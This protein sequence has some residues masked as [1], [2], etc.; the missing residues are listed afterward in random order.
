MKL[1]LIS[2]FALAIAVAAGTLVSEDPGFIVI[3]YGG[4]VVRTT[5]AFFLL[6]ALIVAIA[7][8]ATIRVFAN[9]IELRRRWQRW[10]EEQ[11][12]RRAHRS[13]ANGLLAFASGDFERAER[14]FSRGVDED[15]QPE[16]HYLAAAE[17][18]QA[19]HAPAR[20][21]N[22]LRLAHDLQPEASDAI[23]IKRAEW[24]IENSQLEEARE[25]LDG[26][27]TRQRGNA[28]LL[29]LRLDLIE[30]LGDPDALIALVP[31]L[32][33]A[34]VVSFDAANALERNAAIAILERPHPSIGALHA[35]WR[36]LSK[37]MRADHN[38][39]AAHVRALCRLGADDEAEALVRK[40]LESRWDTTL[41]VLY[42]EI[43]CEPQTK[44]LRK[45]DAWAMTRGD[46]PGLILTRARL[47]IRAGLWGHA[48][49]QLDRLAASEPS[50]L[51]YR[52]QAEA[53]EGMDD[54]EA[55][56]KY[57]R[58]G[59]ELATEVSTSA[60]REAV[61]SVEPAVEGAA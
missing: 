39:L 57:R 25:M 14:L 20:R 45:A 26:L 47:S 41:A 33:R 49:L 27:G 24:L 16:A 44:Q 29:K 22:Y 17:A 38:V 5:F 15:A 56:A 58:L 40:R 30:R 53:A 23:D 37:P 2:L 43:G 34:R 59:L 6:V 48:K 12:R 32:R 36:G 8:Y 50:P 13:L 9:V 10:S 51:I 61:E 35:I 52:L 18:A 1:L 21:D 4:K 54:A 11:R 42:G 55:A 31:D 3:G 28:Q 60:P 7:S 19:M 46:D